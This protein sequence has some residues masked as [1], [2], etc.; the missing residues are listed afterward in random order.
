[1]SCL[2]FNLSEWSDGKTFNCSVEKNYRQRCSFYH[3]ELNSGEEASFGVSNL[4]PGE[5]Q[6]N[7]T[8]LYFRYL[9]IYH[10]PAS[11][12]TYFTKLKVLQIA[13]CNVQEIRNNTFENAT[14]LQN[15]DFFANQISTLEADTFRGATSMEKIIL[16]INQISHIDLNAF[17]GLPNLRYLDLSGNKITELDG[18][19]FAPLSELYDLKLRSNSIRTLDKDT[20]RNLPHLAILDL[21]YNLLET[22]DETLFL[23]NTDLY[24]LDLSNNQIRAL[25]SSMFKHFPEF[26]RIDLSS[27]ICVNDVLRSRYFYY[28]DLENPVDPELYLVKCDNNY[29]YKRTGRICYRILRYFPD[30]VYSW[31]N[32]G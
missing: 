18:R 21:S 10:V 14:D 32:M 28:D 17:R 25:S 13:N 31:A 5:T 22:L 24:Y 1:V 30:W 29:V 20:F 3:V 26:Y 16:S 6:A 9:S 8:E 19:I 4:E 15:F 11:I 23:Y 12:F 27:N 7:I 2:I